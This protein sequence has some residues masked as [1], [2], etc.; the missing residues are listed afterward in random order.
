[1]FPFALTD[2]CSVVITSPRSPGGLLSF[3]PLDLYR[4]DLSLI[5]VN[6]INISFVDAMKILKSL[7]AGFEDGTLLA[8]P[9]IHEVDFQNEVEAVKA[10]EGVLKGAKG[11]YVLVSPK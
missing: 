10:Y 9:L 5:G 1:L 2:L 7:K 6:T 4:E 11:K 3:N 8:P